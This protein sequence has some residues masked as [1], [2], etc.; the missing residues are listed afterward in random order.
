VPPAPGE[1][2][3]AGPAT[4][5]PPVETPVATAAVAPTVATTAVGPAD[6]VTV[7]ATVKP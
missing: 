3:P 1:V 6:N 7:G 4:S 5:V 2:A